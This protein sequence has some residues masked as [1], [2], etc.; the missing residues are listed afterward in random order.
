MSAHPKMTRAEW[1]ASRPRIVAAASSLVHDADYRI[2]MLHASWK[3]EWQLPGGTHDE[4]EDLWRTAVRETF[5]ET[6]LSMPAQPR[7]LTL[8]WTMNPEG[9]AEVWGLFQG[10]LVDDGVLVK[11][12]DEHDRWEMLTI[13]EWAPLLPP[14]QARVLTTAVDMLCNGGCTYLREGERVG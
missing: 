1:L 13:Q 4:G 8:D 6:G 10:P 11:L 3:D 2:L 14:F 12:S 7:L 9:V 5:E